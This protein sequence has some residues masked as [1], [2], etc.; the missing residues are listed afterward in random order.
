MHFSFYLISFIYN[1]TDFILQDVAVH[2]YT[3]PIACGPRRIGIYIYVFFF[4]RTVLINL[5]TIKCIGNIIFN[6][7]KVGIKQYIFNLKRRIIN[8]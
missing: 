4:H 7:I 3:Y 1:G 8:T 2:R 5:K 6:I